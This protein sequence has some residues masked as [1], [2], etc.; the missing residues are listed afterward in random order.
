VAAASRPYRFVAAARSE[1]RQ[2][3]L[4]YEERREGLGEAFARHV[5]RA[6]QAI[7]EAPERWPLRRGTRRYVL[8]GF[9]YTIA[10]RASDDEVVILA[11]AHQRLD[12]RTW[13]QR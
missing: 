3:V 8:R 12:P 6:V 4:W 1:F 2:G 11:V 13:E 5:R 10:Y 7:V 9:P